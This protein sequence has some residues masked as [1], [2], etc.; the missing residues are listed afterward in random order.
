MSPQAT[1]EVCVAVC[2]GPCMIGRLYCRSAERSW[3]RMYSNPEARIR[4]QSVTLLELDDE[5]ASVRICFIP[6]T[7]MLARA[8]DRTGNTDS[9]LNIQK[10]SWIIAQ[11]LAGVNTD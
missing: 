2:Y 6:A 11:N 10:D 3:S 1:T 9:P 5:Q 7:L 8:R 4:L